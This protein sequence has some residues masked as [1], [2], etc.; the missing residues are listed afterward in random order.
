MCHTY[1]Q[2]YV[3]F[4]T[5]VQVTHQLSVKESIFPTP[6]TNMSKETWEAARTVLC[7]SMFALAA[8]VHCRIILLAQEAQS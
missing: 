2:T 1:T 4:P 5:L 3:A 8:R 6:G 7:Y